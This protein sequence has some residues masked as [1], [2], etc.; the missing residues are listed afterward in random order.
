MPC[1]YGGIGKPC[2]R[3]VA[4]NALTTIRQHNNSMDVNGVSNMCFAYR[5]AMIPGRRFACSG[6]DC[7]L[8]ARCVS[9]SGRW[10]C[11][12]VIL[13]TPFSRY[14]VP[15]TRFRDALRGTSRINGDVQGHIYT[16]LL[17]YGKPQCGKLLSEIP[18]CVTGDNRNQSVAIALFS[19]A[20][21]RL[22]HPDNPVK[23][24]YLKQK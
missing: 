17:Q 21:H 12:V 20:L 6:Y 5:S 24:K 16:L 1:P 9:V 10:I 13:S 7:W 3:G 22:H 14:L 11:T 19:Q 18:N 15:A 4:C 2:C 8:R 23:G